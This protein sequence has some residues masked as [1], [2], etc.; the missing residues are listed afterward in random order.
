LRI[1]SRVEIAAL[2]AD[3]EVGAQLP[4]R[5]QVGEFREESASRGVAL[6]L[7][8]HPLR[9][10]RPQASNRSSDCGDVAR[11][12]LDGSHDVAGALGLIGVHVP[13]RHAAASHTSL[14][15]SRVLRHRLSGLRVVHA[16]SPASA[17]VRL[18]T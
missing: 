9:S 13:V 17:V 12:H 2:F 16:V 10:G 6:G 3:V 8:V 5:V 1:A 7:E 14:I 18:R 11:R 4:R 15:V